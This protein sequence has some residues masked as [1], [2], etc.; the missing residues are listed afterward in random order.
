MVACQVAYE[1]FYTGK[2]KG[3]RLAWQNALSSCTLRAH[4]PKGAKELTVS[5]LQSV[6]L[7]LFNNA[8]VLSYGD[9]ANQT[10]LGKLLKKEKRGG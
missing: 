2:F 1:K 8:K 10:N 5:L 4:F 3:R 6:I 9:I 7:L